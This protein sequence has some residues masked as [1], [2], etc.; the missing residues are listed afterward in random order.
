[1]DA[2]PEEYSEQ[3]KNV[4]VS[5]NSEECEDIGQKTMVYLFFLLF[6]Y[7]EKVD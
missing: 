3:E 2:E 7:S 6:Y 1:M 4:G 5:C